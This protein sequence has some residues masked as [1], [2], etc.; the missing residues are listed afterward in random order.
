MPPRPA[1]EPRARGRD[2]EPRPGSPS[3]DARRSEQGGSPVYKRG[4]HPR[5]A[6]QEP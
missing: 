2:P 4:A 3:A 1:E 5:R 6:K